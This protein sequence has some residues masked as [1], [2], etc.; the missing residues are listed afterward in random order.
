MNR[1][2]TPALLS[3]KAANSAASDSAA[4]TFLLQGHVQAL[5]FL[6]EIFHHVCNWRQVR[7]RKIKSFVQCR[8][9]TRSVG[10][11]NGC[12]EY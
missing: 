10:L 6:L 2:E 7:T 3:V 5:V 11:I 9:F 12:D 4:G 1:R 8:F